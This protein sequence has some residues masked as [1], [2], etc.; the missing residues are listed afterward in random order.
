MT[1][2]EIDALIKQNITNNDTGDI[3]GAILQ[4]TLCT[5]NAK[6]IAETDLD[7]DTQTKLNSV[8]AWAKEPQKPV[9]TAQEVGALPDSTVIPST[10]AELADAS[11]YALKSEIPTS[12]AELTDASSYAL[13]T[14]LPTSVAELSDA[15]SY[16]LKTEIPTTV[17]ELS[18]ASSYALKTEIPTT[19]A[20][21]SD[22]SS[23]ALK[24]EV[25]TAV[26]Q[27][28]DASS[29]A[30]KSEIPTAVAQLSDASSY[31]LKTEIP[32]AVAQLS[33]ASS[34][35][36]VS[37]LSGYAQI[38]TGVAG[39]FVAEAA[40]GTYD[41]ATVYYKWQKIGDYVFVNVLNAHCIS[42]WIDVHYELPIAPEPTYGASGLCVNAI[43]GSSGNELIK[44]DLGE[45]NAKRTFHITKLDRTAFNSGN[46]IN[47]VIVYRFR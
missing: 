2:Q 9:Y 42:G 28:S 22:A 19:V 26:A 37:S 16:A 11:S 5:M 14:E 1:T 3:T 23:Y 25:P 30:L 20:E 44:W 35:A 7:T 39:P 38:Q 21:L 27:L 46:V 6:P 18:D 33:D 47:V 12:V 34:Y 43:E 17:A 45:I 40:A 13:K 24:T 10:V 8:P 31:A 15:S 41:W 29:Y 4:T 32:T 36:L